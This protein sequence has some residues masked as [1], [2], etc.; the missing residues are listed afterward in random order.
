MDKMKYERAM[1]NDLDERYRRLLGT[2]SRTVIYYCLYLGCSYVYVNFTTEPLKPLPDEAGRKELLIKTIVRESLDKDWENKQGR[3]IY[4]NFKHQDNICK[5]AQLQFE[6]E[7]KAHYLGGPDWY[8]NNR[9]YVINKAEEYCAVSQTL[10]YAILN[11]CKDSNCVKEQYKKV[12]YFNQTNDSQYLPDIN[13]S[14]LKQV[15]TNPNLVKFTFINAGRYLELRE[16]D[17]DGK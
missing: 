11:Y 3:S 7:I 5:N 17:N 1:F 15:K 9:G 16:K 6:K 2:V 10:Y 14:T 12:K 8:V 13:V 4:K